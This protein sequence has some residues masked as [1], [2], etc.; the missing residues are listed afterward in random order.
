MTNYKLSNTSKKRLS[1]C[2]EKIQ[3]VI[4]EAIKTSPIDFGVSEG[5]RTLEK[6]QAYYR[7]GKSTLNGIDK[8]SR[9]QSMPS[10]AID[11]YAYDK[12]AK[13]DEK[14]LTLLAGHILGTA[15]RLG[16]DLVWGGNWKTFKDMPHFELK[17]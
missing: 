12:G 11:L 8:K 4:K 16:V 6:Q 17:S 14:S 7:D 1:T 15:N 9:H 2:D 3:K 5:H 10:E 13:W